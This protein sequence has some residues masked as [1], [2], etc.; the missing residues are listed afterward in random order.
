MW[1]D[2]CE[3]KPS[4]LLYDHYM[5]IATHNSVANIVSPQE[6]EANQT[7]RKQQSKQ[8]RQTNKQRNTALYITHNNKP[9]YQ[10]TQQYT[11]KYI[12]T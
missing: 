5:R 6:H 11:A 3:A 9:T 7:H 12:C 8:T 4:T 1:G 2:K 10:Q